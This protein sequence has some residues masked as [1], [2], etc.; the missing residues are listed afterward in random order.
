MSFAFAGFAAFLPL[1]CLALLGREMRRRLN[2]LFPQS[3]VLYFLLMLDHSLFLFAYQRCYLLWRQLLMREQVFVDKERCPRV[4][5]GIARLLGREM[6]VLPVGELLRLGDLLAETDSE[7]FLQ[8]HIQQTVLRDHLLD[9]DAVGGC[10][11]APATQTVDIVLERQTDLAHVRVCKEIRQLLRHAD[12][13]ET[14]EETA[15]VGSYLHEGG[16]VMRAALKTR[17]GLRINTYH[18]LRSQIVHGRGNLHRLIDDKHLAFERL[19]GHPLEQLFTDMMRLISHG[20]HGERI[21]VCD[22]NWSRM[23]RGRARQHRS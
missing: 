14:E 21:I 11:I 13:R 8:S 1:M 4:R 10:E 22:P 23:P 15:L 18:L 12:M 16:G 17:S 19:N 2:S 7:E 9:I 20:E 6:R 5:R 3:L